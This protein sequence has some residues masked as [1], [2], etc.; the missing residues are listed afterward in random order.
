MYT[1]VIETRNDTYTKQ[2]ET[3]EDAM[4]YVRAFVAVTNR[5]QWRIVEA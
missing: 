4:L 3:R 2:H 5:A 1:T